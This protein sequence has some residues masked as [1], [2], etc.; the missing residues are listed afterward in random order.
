MSKLKIAM[1]ST[2]YPYRGGIAQFNANLY[3]AFSQ[4]YEV[5]AFNFKRQYPELLFPGKTQMVSETDQ[6]PAIPSER[7]LDSMWPLSYWTTAQK[8]KKWQPDLLVMRYWLPFFAPALGLIAKWVRSEQTKVISIVD[9]AIPHEKRPGDE[10]LSRFFF[11]QNDGLMVMSG[12]VAKD[13]KKLHP[14]ASFR[15]R[16]HPVYDHFGQKMPKTAAREKLQIPP[17]KK[18]VLFFGLVRK[19]KGLD[20]LIEAFKHLSEDYYLLIAGEVY[21]D[22]TFYHQ[23]LK[24]A[25]LDTKDRCGTHF[26][27]ISDQEV[28]SFFG[29]ADLIA[30]PYRSATQ[31]GILAVCLHFDLP[32]VITD[33]GGLKE[34]VA[35]YG[36]GKVVDAPK[37][38][39]LQTAIQTFFDQNEGAAM[40]NQI[41]DY[42]NT[43]NWANFAEFITDYYQDLKKN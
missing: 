33:V 25:K 28:P 35:P 6:A 4:K 34:M 13:L 24:E 27:Y 15:Q 30:L 37:A 18:V 7:T 5:K 23:A 14:K 17:G 12:Q 39:L 43:H 29:A 10:L 8:I 31:S 11:K 41:N 19:Y 22:E 1:L 3:E 36:I 20:L 2:F 9:N 16:P 42:K 26:R 21:G 38:A 32:V 40:Q